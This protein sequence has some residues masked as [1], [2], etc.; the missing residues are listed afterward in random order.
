MSKSLYAKLAVIGVLCALGLNPFPSQHLSAPRSPEVTATQLGPQFQLVYQTNFNQ[1][2]PT[3]W[4]PT[5]APSGPHHWVPSQLSYGSN[6]LEIHVSQARLSEGDSTWYGGA[7]NFRQGQTYGAFSVT[8]SIS[9]GVTKCLAALWPDGPEWPPEVDFQELFAAWPQRTWNQQT[10]HYGPNGVN[11]QIVKRVAG[12]YDQ[13]QTITVEWTPSAITYLLNGQVTGQV[14]GD[15]V[16]PQVP[17]HLVLASNEQISDPR[18]TPTNPTTYRVA[19]VAIYKYVSQPP[20]TTTTTQPPPTTTTTQPPPTTTTT[21]PPPTTTTTQPPPTTTTTQPPPTTTTT[22]PPPPPSLSPEPGTTAGAARA[23]D[24]TELVAATSPSRSVQAAL[25]SRSGTWQA[26]PYPGGQAIGGPAVASPGPGEWDVVIRGLD[27]AVWLDT[28]AQGHWSSWRSLGGKVSAPP[29]LA[30]YGSHVEVLARGLDGALWQR[31]AV[32]GGW[33]Y[34]GGRLA[35][36]TGPAG[37]FPWPG[38]LTVFVQGANHTV[39]EYRG[40]GKRTRIT[41]VG[42][43]WGWTVSQNPAA[44]SFRQGV[45]EVFARNARDNELWHRWWKSSHG[46]SAWHPLGGSLTSGPVTAS[47]SWALSGQ[48]YAQDVYVLGGD[49]KLWN[50]TSNSGE[51]GPWALVP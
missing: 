20:P 37:A 1:P 13:L 23:G 45:V 8:T 17:M 40:A 22:S 14:T 38:D 43:P 51:W 9:D 10:V 42:A 30:A 5:N 29:G 39:W 19:Q 4:T 31:P 12:H 24:G 18:V 49:G 46:W 2:D 35:A 6:G 32:G 34:R 26:V 7:L 27:D 28:Y 33:V 48:D 16:V 36:G 3:H 47:Y 21:Q 25:R 44:S 11:H 41:N 50:R 15:G